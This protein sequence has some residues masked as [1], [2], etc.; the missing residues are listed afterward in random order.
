MA[1]IYWLCATYHAKYLTNFIIFYL[2][3][4]H[5]KWVL[6]ISLLLVRGQRL[7]GLSNFLNVTK[8]IRAVLRFRVLFLCL[9]SPF[10]DYK[11]Y[12]LNYIVK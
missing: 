3:K 7:R 12:C 5:I 2:H 6:L 1:N 10:L 11:L 8:L 9:E 4:S